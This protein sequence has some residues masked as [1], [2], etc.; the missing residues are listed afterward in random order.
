MED[1]ILQENSSWQRLFKL[2][3]DKKPV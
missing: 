2:L 1:N 3:I